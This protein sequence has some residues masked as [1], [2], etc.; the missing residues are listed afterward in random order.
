MV[1]ADI[2]AEAGEPLAAA[3]GAAAVFQ[4]TDVTAETD[5]RDHLVAQTLE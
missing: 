5:G 2:N 4:R 3:L 1:L